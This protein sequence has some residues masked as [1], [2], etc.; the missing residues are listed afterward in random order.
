MKRRILCVRRIP[1]I[2]LSALS[3]CVLLAALPSAARPKVKP[4]SSGIDQNY[5]LALATANRFLEAWQGHDEEAGLLLLTD[6]AKQSAA[7]DRVQNF[8]A[9]HR[10][11]AF[12]ISQGK[13]LKGQRYVF[14]IVLLEMPPA[15]VR[16]APRLRY[17]RLLVV[18]AGENDWIIAKLP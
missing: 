3:G 9:A 8:F 2:A 6:A 13:K 15:G 1:F 16:R 17:S 7:E 18:K 5:M 12:A 4:H 14:P 11:S 10:E